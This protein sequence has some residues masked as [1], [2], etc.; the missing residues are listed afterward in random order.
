MGIFAEGL[1]GAPLR[2][3]QVFAVLLAAAA[4]CILLIPRW[5]SR[6]LLAGLLAV[7][8]ALTVAVGVGLTQ[9]REFVNPSCDDPVELSV[10]LPVD[11][12]FGFEE[13]VGEF[14]EQYVD[15]SGCKLANVTAYSAPWPDV[16]KALELGWE[17]D[18]ELESDDPLFG[19]APQRDVGPRP[20]LW[21]AESPAQVE[22]AEELLSGAGS[23]GV[24]DADAAAPIGSTPLVMAV[25]DQIF[26]TGFGPDNQILDESPA[27]LAQRLG[28]EYGLSVVR[29]DPTL[30]HT[31]LSF[32]KFLYDDD[33]EAVGVQIEKQLARSAEDIGLGLPGSDTSLIC[34]L[35]ETSSSGAG[36][37]VLTTER[38]LS[39]HNSGAPL[40]DDCPLRV[41]SRSGYSPLYL[42]ELGSLDYRAARLGWDDPWA[43]RRSEV[44]EDLSAWLAG[45][46]E[47]WSPERIGIRGNG[48]DGA[49]IEGDLNFALNFQPSGEPLTAGEPAALLSTYGESRVPTNVLLAIDDSLTM[50][51]QIG[52]EGLSR[53][54]LAVE[55]VRAAL[56]YL[57]PRDAA[58]LW[59]FPA[60]GAASH[61]VLLEIASGRGPQDADLL[62]DHPLVRGVDL[63]Q[64]LVEGVEA[65]EASSG[66]DSVEAMVVLTDGADRDDSAIGVADVIDRVT[67]SEVSLYIIAVGDAS[68]RSKNF[69]DMT[70][71]PRI[72]CIE[73][74]EGQ[75]KTTFDSLFG[76]LW[77]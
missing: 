13:G 76:Q 5:P 1:T 57:S 58:G 20:D 19:F 4:L 61:D 62:S 14:A 77:S 73:A 6:K 22:L 41:G 18:E 29:A 8:A 15:D 72:R 21:L 47:A 55:G 10:L 68:C 67:D 49:A 46:D 43:D 3:L 31:A 32:L 2:I 63:H 33:A 66:E 56:G 40:G 28:D 50:G 52:G 44:A 69:T 35:T 34:G 59:T 51:T 74:E 75:I 54:E 7:V 64:T 70:A 25:P 24:L 65:L 38:A 27:S 30:S 71:S 48:Y 42:E 39:Q 26:D 60:E 9:I 37:A 11:G 45:E 12:A 23:D 17:V 16:Q 53:F 36:T